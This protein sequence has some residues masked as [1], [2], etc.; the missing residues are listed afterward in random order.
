MDIAVVREI[1]GTGSIFENLFVDSHRRELGFDEVEHPLIPDTE[2]VAQDVGSV[3]PEVV[4]PAA[5]VV[6]L[7][8]LRA[9]R[10]VGNDRL[11]RLIA[12][13]FAAAHLVGDLA[14]ERVQFVT[15][16][17][18]CGLSDRRGFLRC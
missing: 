13:Q 8:G 11:H 7:H 15:R 6:H 17:R 3:R 10:E 4:L 5:V 12:G 14:G 2:F 18:Q 9:T 16:K 1:E